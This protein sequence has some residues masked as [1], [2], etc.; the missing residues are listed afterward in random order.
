MIVSITDQNSFAGIT[1]HERGQFQFFLVF[2]SSRYIACDS[3][4]TNQFSI[5]RPDRCLDHIEKHACARQGISTPLL[6]YLRFAFFQNTF[7]L[8]F[9][10]AGFLVAEYIEFR[11]PDDMVF[12]EPH[13]IL[14]SLI[15][16]KINT[17]K[18]FHPDQI[19]NIFK[20]A[21]QSG[22]ALCQN[23]IDL[24]QIIR[25]DLNQFFQIDK[26][27]VTDFLQ[28]DHKKNGQKEQCHQSD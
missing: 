19:R 7:V 8:F 4:N 9:K 11:F 27:L 15:T 6:D 2:F 18:I 16:S 24:V 28:A 21:F 1:V 13:I 5:R 22:F 10:K 25:S 17:C 23:G 20:N 12:R 26:Q 3:Q 14:V